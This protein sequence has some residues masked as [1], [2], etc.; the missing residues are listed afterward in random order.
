MELVLLPLK[1]VERGQDTYR[2]KLRTSV[3]NTM[4]F[5]R[6]ALRSIIHYGGV[7]HELFVTEI[8]PKIQNRTNM[9]SS[10]G[11][12]LQALP[13]V[14]L[15]F[16]LKQCYYLNSGSVAISCT[17][18]ICSW[19]DWRFIQVGDISSSSVGV[20]AVIAANQ[21]IRLLSNVPRFSNFPVN[22]GKETRCIALCL[23]Y[24]RKV[25]D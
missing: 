25:S 23:L 17:P 21:V 20:R 1:Y 22:R 7:Y 10:R 14:H 11:G 19:D 5:Q 13:G 3:A 18:R 9:S 4:Q 15:R 12:D 24:L 8:L 16:P 2:L 6:S